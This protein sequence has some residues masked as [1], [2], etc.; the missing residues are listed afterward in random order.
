SATPIGHTNQSHHP[1]HGGRSQYVR[2]CLNAKGSFF[3][4][5]LSVSL[6]VVGSYRCTR[7]ACARARRLA[8]GE[9]MSVKK[10]DKNRCQG[11]CMTKSWGIRTTSSWQSVQQH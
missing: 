3:G 2:T 9:K 7:N 6:N 1:G 11:F 10:L 4:H 8:Q 5:S